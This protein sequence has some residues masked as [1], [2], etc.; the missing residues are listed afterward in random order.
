MTD[1]DMTRAAREGLEAF[2]RGDG[3]GAFDRLRVA[4]QAGTDNLD[5]HMA[6]AI[7]S[8]ILGRHEDA[9]T[10]ARTVVD[11]D[12]RN[13]E[14]MIIKADA[15]RALQGPRAAGKAYLAA[16]EAAPPKDRLSQ[17]LAQELARARTACAEEAK[18]YEAFL[19]SHMDGAGF[20]G[21]DGTTRVDQALDIMFGRRQV[22]TQQP[23]KFYFPELPQVQFYDP[24]LFPW[25]KTLEA[26]TAEIQAE[27]HAAWIGG[28]GVEPYVPA[29]TDAP[30]HLDTGDL[31]G[32]TRWSAFHFYKDGLPRADNQSRCPK[33]MAAL[34][35][36]PQPSVPTMSPTA[37]YSVLKPGAVIPPHFGMMNTRLIGHLPL[38]TPPDCV[39]RVGNQTRQWREGELLV[40]DDSVEHEAR[41]G[42]Q[43]TRIVLLFDLWRPEL[44]Q[45]ERVFVSQVYEGMAAYSDESP[46][47]AS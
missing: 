16:I 24:D 46:Q 35:A 33:T 17:H 27:A 45:E 18:T 34:E 32:N 6:L 31:I 3:Q 21:G 41:N 47:H 10:A 29:D 4:A 9:L 36:V 38:I 14:A 12:P 26:A 8:R 44:S 7:V 2:R 42:S 43:E 37:L 28:D 39:L 23:L 30:R 22:F 1:T 5:V 20:D 40:F 11:R 15:I 25:R 19:R 13:C